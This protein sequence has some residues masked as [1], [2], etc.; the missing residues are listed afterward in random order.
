MLILSCS[1]GFMSR[2][3]SVSIQRSIAS[4][5]ALSLVDPEACCNPFEGNMENWS[6]NRVKIPEFY[7]RTSLELVLSKY[8]GLYTSTVGG[9]RKHS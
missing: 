1:Q 8:T 2:E 6:F 4:L 9:P 5:L 7:R 3:F